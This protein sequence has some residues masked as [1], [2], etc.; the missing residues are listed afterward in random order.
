MPLLLG[1]SLYWAI[2]TGLAGNKIA[3]DAN[4]VVG[5]NCDS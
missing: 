2:T 4:G 5:V 3:N 1:R